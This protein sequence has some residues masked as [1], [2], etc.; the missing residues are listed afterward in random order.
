MLKRFFGSGRSETKSDFE[1]VS[2]DEEE[3]KGDDFVQSLKINMTR[4]IA[5]AQSANISLQRE[6]A[7]RLA[8]EAVKAERQ[9]QIVECGGLRLLVPLTKSVDKEVRRLAAHALANLSVNRENQVLMANEGAIEMLIGLLGTPHDLA[10]R[11]SAKALAN[12]GVNTDNKRR[13]VV[14]GAVPPLVALMDSENVSVRIEAVAAVA[15]L[16]VNSLNESDIVAGG[17]LSPIVEGAR[18]AMTELLMGEGSDESDANFE[19]LAAQCGRALRNLSANADH[20]PTIRDLGGVQELRRMLSYPSDR[21]IS[22]AR[23][24]M[25]NIEPRTSSKSSRK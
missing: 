4:L 22:Q 16:A 6:V 7:E 14:A 2:D 25:K 3:G 10:Q 5:Y 20:R 23:R 15:N 18:L 17:G 12:L 9:Q 21:I 19:E 13:I 11:Q 1:I 8:N 24:A